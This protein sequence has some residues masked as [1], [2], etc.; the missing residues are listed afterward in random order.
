MAPLISHLYELGLMEAV[1][2]DQKECFAA[3]PEP[4]HALAATIT[5]ALAGKETGEEKVIL[6]ALCGHGLLDLAAYDDYLHGRMIDS[7]LSDPD[8]AAAL[9][10]VPVLG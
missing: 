5:E 6:T 9:A 2:I 3:A 8:L 10:R 1:A 7:G 4:T